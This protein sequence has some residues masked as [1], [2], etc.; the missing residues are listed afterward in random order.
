MNKINHSVYYHGNFQTLG[1]I[2]E[3]RE[4]KSV[5]LINPGEYK[6][7]GEKDCVVTITVITGKMKINEEEYKSHQTR[8][9]GIREQIVIKAE[10]VSIFLKETKGYRE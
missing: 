9:V 5:T 1:V 10:T 2:T 8:E 4:G 6:L 7:S 3:E